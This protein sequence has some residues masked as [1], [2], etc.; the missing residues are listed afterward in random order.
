M[1]VSVPADFP[2]GP[3]YAGIDNDG[4]VAMMEAWIYL[5]TYDTESVPLSV[6]TRDVDADVSQVLVRQGL[7]VIDQD[8]VLP[9]RGQR[10]PVKAKAVAVEHPMFATWWAVWP[11]KQARAAAVKAFTKALT[12]V[13]FADLLE[14]TYRY[15]DDPH[16]DEA[17]TP[18]AAT[19]L[20]GERWNDAPNPPRLGSGRP[21]AEDKVAAVLAMGQR[22]TSSGATPL[23]RSRRLGI[24]GSR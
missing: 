2:R 16:R 9:R 19:W 7:V 3:A 22:L 21:S 24:E 4:L 12:K 8:R 15:T 17:F 5:A 20:N 1:N 11:R 10:A 23:F 6:W 14:A 18:H 13:E